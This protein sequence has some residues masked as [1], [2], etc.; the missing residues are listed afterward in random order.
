MDRQTLSTLAL[1][2]ASRQNARISAPELAGRVIT[3]LNVLT[4]AGA[5]AVQWGIGAIIDLWPAAGDGGYSPGGYQ[6]A[7]ALMVVLQ[8]ESLVWYTVFRKA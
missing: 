1:G 6:A 3:E 4:F 7:F 2:Q 8:I 5:F